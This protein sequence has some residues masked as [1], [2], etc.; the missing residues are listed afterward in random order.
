MP[1]T[2]WILVSIWSAVV[3]GGSLYYMFLQDWLLK[4]KQYKAKEY[5]FNKIM[6]ESNALRHDA[7]GRKSF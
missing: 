2:F 1:I 4:R 3:F 5:R 7:G 6:R